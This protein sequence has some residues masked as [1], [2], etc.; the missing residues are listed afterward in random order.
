[1]NK[2]RKNKIFLGLLMM[3]GLLSGCSDYLDV[4]PEKDVTTIKTLFQQRTKVDEWEADCYSFIA[5][6]A[7]P[8]SNI[9]LTASDELVGNQ[10]LRDALRFPLNG[11]YIGDGVQ[12]V[13]NPYGNIWRG[14]RYYDAIRYCNIFIEN[15]P[16]TYNMTEVEKKQWIAEVKVLKAFLYFDLVR[17]YGPI[18]LV[19]KNISVESS[20]ENMKQP[21]RPVEECFQAMLSL[22]DDAMDNGLLPK[23]QQA[24]SHSAY[25]SRES[26]LALKAMILIY[27]ASPLFNGNS[28]F[29]NFKNKDGEQLFPSQ[30]DKEKWHEAALACDIA[31]EEAEKAGYTL[32]SGTNTKTTKL[33]N[34]MQD[35]ENRVLA[36]AFNNQE[37]LFMVK[38]PNTNMYAEYKLY[39]YTLPRFQSSDY[40]NYNSGVY[41]S[42]SPTMKMVEMY[43]TANGLPIEEDPTW[44]YSGRFRNMTVENDQ[45][46][47]ANVIPADTRVL[48]E[49]LRREPRFYADIAADRTYFQRGPAKQ[50]AWSTDYNLIV[51]AHQGESFGT[52]ATYINPREPQNISGYWLKKGLNSS[53]A[54]RSYANDYASKG[55]DPYPVIRLAELY[56]WQAEAWNEYEGP[57]EKVYAAL[58]K[59]RRRAGIPTVQESWQRAKHPEL[60]KDLAGLRSIIQQETNIEMAF[61]GRRY[62][63]LLRWKKGGELGEP[64]K[65]WNVVGSTDEAFYNNWQGP[66]TVWSKRKFVAP[67]DY[68]SPIRSEERM[69]SGVVQNLGW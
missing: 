33:L 66:V 52:Q 15:T 54:T 56:L 3:A 12:S 40:T 6:L 14:D 1:M 60:V 43:Y 10:Y 61:E 68:F 62:W 39:T 7:T 37:A 2:I 53:I 46:T 9:A 65:G 4:V 42:L 49:H 30:A 26:A 19:P 32:V 41:G 18:V 45:S 48:Q 22:I 35:C 69:N 51:K 50:N 55:N 20:I 27:R 11:L 63:N 47:Y 31:V 59:V 17:H 67:R 28:D 29:A 5:N 24:A 57:S 8:Q 36:P 25:F 64:L 23:S 44:D 13:Q 58:N 38:F 16:D 34:V 21:R